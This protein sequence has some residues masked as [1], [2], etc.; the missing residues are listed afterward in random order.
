LKDLVD[1]ASFADDL[2]HERRALWLIS[3]QHLIDFLQFPGETSV[4]AMKVDESREPGISFE[5][6]SDILIESRNNLVDPLIFFE[7]GNVILNSSEVKVEP[8]DEFFPVLIYTTGTLHISLSWQIRL[9]TV[10]GKCLL[11]PFGA[12][13]LAPHKQLSRAV[14]GR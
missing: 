2:T 3:Q 12:V 5:C 4:A 10:V 14:V 1:L 13:L 8:F 6:F 7:L 11:L 9:L